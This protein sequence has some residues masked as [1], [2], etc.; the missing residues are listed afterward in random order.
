MEDKLLFEMF[1]S[2]SIQEMFLRILKSKIFIS[3]GRLLDGITDMCAKSS[4][5][6]NKGMSID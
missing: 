4:C 5:S 3:G 6:G 2:L 1:L